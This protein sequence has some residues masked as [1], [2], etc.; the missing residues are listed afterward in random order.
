M[1]AKINQLTVARILTDGIT[2]P[3]ARPGVAS[4]SLRDNL[5]TVRRARLVLTA[6]PIA[7]TAALDYGS[8]KL[9]DLPDRNI[10]LLGMEVDLDV[11]KQGNTNGIVA[12]T[13][14]SMAV[15]TAAASS[16]TLSS[17]MVDVIEA[18]ALTTDALTVAFERHSND[19]LTATFPRRLAD[20]PTNAL[21]L[22][23]SATTL[24]TAD[25]S[26]AV[27]GTVDIFYAD[28]GNLSS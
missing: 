18:V 28:L 24:I 2:V 5:L 23:L 12:A 11:V 22:N 8:V 27:T 26:V 4:I 25:S 13:D 19:Q 20:G 14:L 1:S 6:T 16:T 15:G 10:M 17:T 9:L 21:F 7:V 3:L